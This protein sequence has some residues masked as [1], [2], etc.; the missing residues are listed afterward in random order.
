MRTWT[1]IN[2]CSAAA[3]NASDKGALRD[4]GEIT[5]S[6]TPDSMI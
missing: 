4:P 6:V 5:T 2:L 1:V 3:K